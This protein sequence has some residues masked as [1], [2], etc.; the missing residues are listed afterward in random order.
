MGA[1]EGLRKKV[2]ARPRWEAMRLSRRQGR[3]NALYGERAEPLPSFIGPVEDPKLGGVGICCSG[4]GIRSAAFNLGALQSLQD[5]RELEKASYLAAV[6]GG[7]Y[8]AAAFSMVAQTWPTGSRRP[9]PGKDQHDDS[10]PDLLAASPPFARGSPEE[11]YL[12]NRSSYMAPDGTGK[13][14][15]AY[16]V[17]LG[18][19]FNL[20]FV[21]LPIFVLALALGEIWYRPHLPHL[22]GHCEAT[23]AGC[24]AHIG[25]WG[26]VPLAAL[27]LSAGLAMWGMLRRTTDRRGRFLQI[28]STRVLLGAGVLA[29]LLVLVP[30]LVE[31][32]HSKSLGGAS[33][34]TGAP[35]TGVGAVGGGAGLAAL[36][37]GVLSQLRQGFATPKKALEEL[38]SAQKRLRSLSKGT[39]LLIAYVA[40]ALVGPLLLAAVFVFGVSIALAKSPHGINTWV[41][42]V[43]AGTLALFIVL[44][45]TADLTSWSLH[46]FYKRRLSSAFALKRI[47][48]RDMTPQE[49]ER[50]QALPPVGYSEE[51]GVAIE[52]D[53]GELVAL[54]DT[55]VRDRPWPTL[56]VCAAANVSDPGA[57]PP[58]RKVTSFTFSP[59]TVGGPLVGAVS[60]DL[61][62]S[63]FGEPTPTGWRAKLKRVSDFARSV[64]LLPSRRRRR[65]SDLS[66]QAA[67]AMSGA[68]IS[69]SMG[70]MTRRP[71]TFLLALANVRLGVW[72]PNP[73]WVMGIQSRDLALFG[74]PR[75]LYLVNEL[76]GRNRV[77][78]K[79]LYVTDGG[80]YENLGLVELLRRGCRKIYCFDASGGEGLEALG[81]ALALARSELRVNID[82]EPDNLFPD[83]NSGEAKSSAVRVDF[84]YPD[85][86]PGA[87]PCTLVYARNVM[88]ATSP[89]DV[90][91]YHKVDP[92]FPNDS[93]VDQLY[94]DQRFE[95]YRVLGERAGKQAVKAMK[96]VPPPGPASA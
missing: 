7:S 2:S 42:E 19:V 82:I 54:S 52:R 38:T 87:E 18:L 20:V 45:A 90:K 59:Y 29:F 88:T 93:T 76:L 96:G 21:S 33:A 69:P 85:D 64:T 28:S 24:V 1:D 22:V 46:P 95:S 25:W 53:F 86:E 39:R 65:V 13:L 89:W 4:G 27:G 47:C 92:R 71:F 8:I 55:A 15:L 9:D 58:G 74:R 60:T 43:G 63:T 80:H 77:G 5:A 73:R 51:V 61:L 6:S 81:D 48:P 36:I 32:F 70:K 49:R 44:Y 84:Q 10:D 41:V 83:T 91:A 40:G 78:A 56:L 11:Q 37:A 16:R 26:I 79:Y 30:T 62:E 67:V 12:R 94:T 35:K 3:R 34:T 75:P 17:V 31:A 68:A 50:A 72:V 66:L 14:F 23:P 57:T